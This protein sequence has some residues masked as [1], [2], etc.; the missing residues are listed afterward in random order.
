MTLVAVDSTQTVQND[1]HIRKRVVQ[2][3]CAR[4]R[5]CECVQSQEEYKGA[6]VY[7]SCD[8]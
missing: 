6:P 3:V 5:A 1:C 2:S 8:A 4:A 7:R